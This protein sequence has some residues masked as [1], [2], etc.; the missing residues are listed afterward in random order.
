MYDFWFLTPAVNL[1]NRIIVQSDNL[2]QFIAR[3]SADSTGNDFSFRVRIDTTSDRPKFPLNRTKPLAKRLAPF[4]KI[5]WHAPSSI[6]IDPFGLG[7]KANHFF[8][9]F[10]GSPA[11]QK[12]C[13]RPDLQ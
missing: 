9:W 6:S 12:K 7:K 10:K 1:E 3:K 2:I 8:R 13:P 4:S 11:G 5:A